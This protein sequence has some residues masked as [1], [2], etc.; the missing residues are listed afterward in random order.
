MAQNDEGLGNKYYFMLVFMVIS[1]TFNTVFT[2]LQNSYYEKI[3]GVP[4]NHPWVQTIQMFIGEFYCA[5]AWLFVRQ[6]F[7][8]EEEV[9]RIK[10]INDTEEGAIVEP[11]K[12]ETKP[13]LFMISCSCDIIGTTLLNFALL[14]MSG[15]VFQM[16]RGGIII[17][18]CGFM[19]IFLGKKPKNYQWLGVGIVFTGIFL[20]GLATMIDSANHAAGDADKTTVIGIV[21]LLISLVFQGFQ[22][23]WQ[24]KIIMN[25]K[26]HPMQIVAWEGLFGTAF[27]LIILPILQVIPCNFEGKEKICT[28]DSDGNY[29]IENTMFALRQSF[30]KLPVFFFAVGQTFSIGLYNFFGIML[31]KYS[32]SASRAVMD[33]ARTLLVWIFFLSVPMASGL[34][35][36]HFLVLQL[37]GFIVMV[38]G[39]VIY[40]GL[41]VIPFCGFNSH[42]K[43]S[44]ISDDDQALMTGDYNELDGDEQ[45]ER[46][47]VTEKRDNRRS[48]MSGK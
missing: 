18:T 34:V 1:G 47:S 24:E 39:Q 48:F 16:L 33:S 6:R 29:V 43:K 11:E 35:I 9:E 27:F 19:I 40:N 15:S 8:K 2:K 10:K 7:M 42:F 28:P 26:C 36:E 38:L 4:F 21:F 46:I 44:K 37:I 12:P 5:I 14:N 23:V 30:D 22:F 41:I 45:D 17:F 25:Y 32:S 13:W 31:V 20:V 3:L